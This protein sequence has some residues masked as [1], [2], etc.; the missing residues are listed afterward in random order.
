MQEA[1][2]RDFLGTRLPN[3]Q[4]DRKRFIPQE[5][6]SRRSINGTIGLRVPQDVIEAKC[7]TLHEA[8]ESDTPQ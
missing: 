1:K 7:Q 8:W 5:E 3:R 2:L 6:M 4:E